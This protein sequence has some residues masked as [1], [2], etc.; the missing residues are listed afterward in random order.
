MTPS[1]PRIVYLL[2]NCVYLVEKRRTTIVQ[3]L[4]RSM[5]KPTIF[6]TTIVQSLIRSM[7]VPTNFRTTIVQSLIRSM[8]VPTNFR[9][10]IVQ[11]L[12]RSMIVP[13]NFRTTC[14]LIIRLHCGVS[15]IAYF[16]NF[17]KTINE[18]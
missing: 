18:F 6:R 5:I 16:V 13:T 4:I 17:T 11:S 8:I 1:K 14:M 2:F 3:S 15:E 7:I 10:T 9:T 12:I